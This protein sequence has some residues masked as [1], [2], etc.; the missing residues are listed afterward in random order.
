MLLAFSMVV[1]AKSPVENL[2]IPVGIFHILL[3]FWIYEIGVY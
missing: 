1:A 2:S 3:V